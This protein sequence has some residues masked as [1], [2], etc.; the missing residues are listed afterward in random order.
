MQSLSVV[1]VYNR[2]L[3]RGGEDEVFESEGKLLIQNGCDVR[4]VTEQTEAPKNVCQKVGL[5][6]ECVWSRKW[7]KQFEALLRRSRPDVVHVHNVFP[8]I[9]PS[10]YYACQ[11]ANVPVVQ[12]LHNYRLLCPASTFYRDGHICEDCVEHSLWRGVRHGCYQQSRSGTAAIALMLQV[13]RKKN[14]WAQKIDRYIALTEF[15]REKFV[16]AGLPAEKFRV[17]PNFVDPDPGE[18]RN[19]REYAMFVGRLVPWKGIE[20]LLSAWKSQSIP[21]VIVGDGPL[22]SEI[23]TSAARGLLP[24]VSY[25]GR[26][27]REKTIAAMKHARFLVF[28]SEWYEGFPMT[29]AEAFACSVPVICSGLGSM[30]EIV[31]DGRTGL[32]FRSGDAEDLAAKVRWAW[33]HPEEM[34]IMGRNARAEYEA[35][36]TANRNYEMLID[37]YRDAIASRA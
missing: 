7:H 36:Y 11:E 32:H 31:A 23:E 30:K 12:T 15:A 18:S 27:S 22:Q 25:R 35:K 29:I 26:M 14:T 6:I 4:L 2:Y 8:V 9:S 21:L 24:A 3:N 17:K 28:P 20:T 13:H 1:S 5:A 19:T 33:M 10:V 37:I 34:E 16:A